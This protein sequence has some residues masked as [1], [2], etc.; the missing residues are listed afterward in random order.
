MNSPYDPNIDVVTPLEVYDV[1][2][3]HIDGYIYDCVAKTNE[4]DKAVRVPV[5][6]DKPEDM[7][8]TEWAEAHGDAE[9]YAAAQVYFDIW[10]FHDGSSHFE[11]MYRAFE[12]V[13]QER[14]RGASLK[15]R[16]AEGSIRFNT[17]SNAME[18][19]Q[20]GKWIHIGTPVSVNIDHDI[21]PHSTY[22]GT[23]VSVEFR[24]EI[25]ADGNL[26][27]S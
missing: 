13:A 2:V 6:R 9:V 24:G 17:K 3:R 18:V 26:T 7:S 16:H 4:G 14:R 15:F 11:L 8:V 5:Y 21:G 25:D 1:E 12:H 19:F 22:D 10:N 20:G 27:I 23:N